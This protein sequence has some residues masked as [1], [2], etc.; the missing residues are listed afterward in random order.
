MIYSN[1]L[2]GFGTEPIKYLVASSIAR[3][4][5]G[6]FEKGYE[7]YDL[8]IELNDD[9]SLEKLMTEIKHYINLINK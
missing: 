2:F 3:F 1:Y 4:K 6:R 8:M 7:I 5:I 9:K